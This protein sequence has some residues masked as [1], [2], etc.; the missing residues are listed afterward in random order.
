MRFT[1][2][3]SRAR[4]LN[5]VTKGMAGRNRA[6]WTCRRIDIAEEEDDVP[7]SKFV[8]AIGNW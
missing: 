7:V 2:T 6:G 8:I 4:K 1:G 3:R 5:V